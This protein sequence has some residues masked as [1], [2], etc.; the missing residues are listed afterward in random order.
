LE[1]VPTIASALRVHDLLIKPPNVDDI[2]QLATRYCGS[3][4]SNG[5]GVTRGGAACGRLDG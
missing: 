2:V 1:V 3:G 5:I 4:R